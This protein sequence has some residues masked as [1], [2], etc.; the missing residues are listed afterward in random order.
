MKVEDLINHD[1]STIA[2]K[3]AFS[4]FNDV[5]EKDLFKAKVGFN[6]ELNELENYLVGVGSCLAH[7]LSLC[8][9]LQDAVNYLSSFTPSK[10]MKKT[11]ITKHSYL[12]YNI[13]NYIIR[14]QSLIDR[15]LSLVT[16]VFHLRI[17]PE[18]IF[19]NDIIIHPLIKDS[20]IEKP[21][22]KLRKL[23]RKYQFKRNSIIHHGSYQEEKLRKLEAYTFLINDENNPLK[24]ND[25]VL[26]KNLPNLTKELTKEIVNESMEEFSTFNQ[27]LFNTIKEIFNICLKQF[28]V[29]K[30]NFL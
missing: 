14:T 10:R 13:E 30:E 23:L 11:G 21:L 2:S 1:F 4:I 28:K 15:I 16:A 29:I 12:H 3:E 18:K 25:P 7:L 9:Q 6:R 26:A 20:A 24:D 8:Q 27:D 22:R 17:N 5:G 19:Y